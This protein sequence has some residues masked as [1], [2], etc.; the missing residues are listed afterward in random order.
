[1]GNGTKVVAWL[2]AVMAGG[3]AGCVGTGGDGAAEA[4]GANP[5]A[6]YLEGAPVGDDERISGEEYSRLRDEARRR[7]VVRVRVSYAR[8]I[9]MVPD[10]A[11]RE[12]NAVEARQKFASLLA[13][14]GDEVW[15]RNALELTNPELGS[16]RLYVTMRGLEI[17]RTAPEVRMMYGASH[18]SRMCPTPAQE[19]A[20]EQA[21]IAQGEVELLAVLNVEAQD[22]AI[23]AAGQLSFSPSNELD[24][25]AAD[26]RERLLAAAGDRVLNL[27]A[28]R[29]ADLGRQ[30][31]LR[32]R[33]GREGYYFL[34][35]RPEVLSLQPVG[36]RDAAAPDI[37][38]VAAYRAE[39]AR[40][41]ADEL[42]RELGVDYG[43]A[44][45]LVGHMTL[46]LG[47]ASGLRESP[48][49]YARADASCRGAFD[50]LLTPL[51]ADLRVRYR[52][53]EQCYGA[54]VVI[55][56]AGVEKLRLIGDR[57]LAALRFERPPIL[58]YATSP[59]V[60]GPVIEGTYGN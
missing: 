27:A 53:R 17:L 22:F 18:D 10:A 51:G 4:P 43:R 31:M 12:A 2:L 32:L 59:G 39:A 49:A 44:G 35:T 47:A 26:L 25:Q 15:R 41:P 56:P 30:P 34:R 48:A 5:P 60:A 28:A 55:T 52:E 13:R 40:W 33:V 29:V 9:A 3:L 45:D 38:D 57:R 36:W 7:E 54:F 23:D 11:Q 46:R 37:E 21:L 42:L 6:N 1:M 14:L 20:I 8:G 50:Q 58:N 19:E 16:A 24:Q